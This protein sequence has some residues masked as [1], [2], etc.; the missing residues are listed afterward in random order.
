[1]NQSLGA[2]RVNAATM[3]GKHNYYDLKNEEI[4][5]NQTQIKTAKKWIMKNARMN[6]VYFHFISLI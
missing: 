3:L 4:F 2:A 6:I 5:Q 1:M